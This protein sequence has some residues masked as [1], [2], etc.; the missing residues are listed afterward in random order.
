MQEGETHRRGKNH[1][2]VGAEGLDHLRSDIAAKS[3]ENKSYQSQNDADGDYLRRLA[4]G[5][6]F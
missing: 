5:A 4:V 1:G 3:G 6:G 2:V